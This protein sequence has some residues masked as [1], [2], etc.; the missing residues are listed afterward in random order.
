MILETASV[1]RR[2]HPPNYQAE[3][4]FLDNRS[5]TVIYDR[6]RFTRYRVP[7]GLVLRP[8]SNDAPFYV[9][10][11]DASAGGCY[12]ETVLPLQRG[13]KLSMV[14]WLE[15]SNCRPGVSCGPATLEW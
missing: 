15:S 8:E 14:I 10:V 12:V 4:T 3:N 5:V 11:S 2:N 1:I 13:T 9:S 6:R 7:L